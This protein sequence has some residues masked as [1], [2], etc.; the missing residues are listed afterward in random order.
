MKM[1]KE[2]LHLETFDESQIKADMFNGRLPKGEQL[3]IHHDRET[4]PWNMAA[5]VNPYAHCVIYVGSRTIDGKEVHEVVHV[6]KA[7]MKGLLKATITRQD[8]LT[9]IK[10]NNKVF[11]G[12]FVIADGGSAS[13][14]TL[15]FGGDLAYN[16]QTPGA[17]IFVND[18]QTFTMPTAGS[19]AVPGLGGVAALTGVGLVGRR[20]RR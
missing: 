13:G 6:A 14:V 15:T 8:V 12:R 16:L 11:L 20:R 17:P 7:S 4:D 2:S 10:P 1:D 18:T 9:V 5:R 19:S 3:W